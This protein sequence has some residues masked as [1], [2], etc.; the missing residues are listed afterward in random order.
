VRPLALLLAFGLAGC[1]SQYD[2][3]LRND[4]GRPLDVAVIESPSG[5]R[6]IH[7][8]VA[9]QGWFEFRVDQGR[10]GWGRVLRVEDV[11]HIARAEADLSGV[12]VFRGRAVFEGAVLRIRPIGDRERG[13]RAAPAD[14]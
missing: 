9:A 8:S 13:E 6:R 7:A 2:V 5:R 12:Q 1:A 3:K 11:D 4:S 10:G 14:W